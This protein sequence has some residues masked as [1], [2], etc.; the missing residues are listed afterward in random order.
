MLT[1]RATGAHLAGVLKVYL[2]AGAH[3]YIAAVADSTGNKCDSVRGTRRHLFSHPPLLPGL[4][5]P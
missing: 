3:L 4:L 1:E 5:H 2:L